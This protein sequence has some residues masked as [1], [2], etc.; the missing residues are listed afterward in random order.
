MANSGTYTFA[1]PIG[2]LTLNAFS[3]IN[4]KRAEIL[5]EHMENSYL[6]CNLLQAD[7]SADGINWWTVELINQP[8]TQGVSTYSIAANIISVLDVYVSPNNGASGLNRLLFPFSRTDYA[9]LGNPAEQGFPTSFWFDRALSPSLTLWP[10]PDGSTTYL[11]SYYAYTQTQ[12]A[13]LRQGGNAAI[14]Y[15]W[16]DAYVA[17]L[18][19]RL[20]RHHAPALETVRK[21][22]KIDAY[23]RASKQVEP[24]PM[25]L[26]V[27]LASYF[28]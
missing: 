1:P 27:G 7:W 2:V 21:Q 15:W 23:N 10:V 16:L 14:P 4:V 19:H 3:R 17:D 24:A 20:S 25:Y 26:S 5:S 9:S 6:E 12:D 28:R 18:A 8:L 11:M 22:D 13:N